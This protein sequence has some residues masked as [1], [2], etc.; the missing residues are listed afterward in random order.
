MVSGDT[1]HFCSHVSG[2]GEDFVEPL[3]VI[4]HKFSGPLAADVYA[5]DPGYF[6]GE[7]VGGFSGMVPIGT[8]TI[9]C[10]VETGE[11][12]LMLQDSFSQWTSAD[13]SEADHQYLHGRKDKDSG[14]RWTRRLFLQFDQGMGLLW[15]CFFMYLA[16]SV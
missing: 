8:C 11:V 4:G 5:M 14:A 12:G 2:H 16:S 3:Q 15:V 6:L 1:F 10:P 13:I 7:W 9:D